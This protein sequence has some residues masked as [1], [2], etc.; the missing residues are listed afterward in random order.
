MI[1]LSLH[2]KLFA[3][4]AASTGY[5][6]SFHASFPAESGIGTGRQV[7]GGTNTKLG[8]PAHP[9]T[10]ESAMF[11]YTGPPI[12]L[13]CTSLVILT[14]LLSSCA[15][16]EPPFEC[17]DPLGC[18]DLPPEAPI[19]IGVLQ[20]LS[21]KIASLG[22]EQVR[23]IELAVEKR[24]GKALGRS[25]LLQIENTGC[26]GEGGAN[27]ALKLIADPMIPAIIGTTCSGAARTA[28]R[29]MSEAG[30]TM[31]SG[32]N[33]APYLTSITGKAAPDFQPGYFRTAYNEEA[34]GK[35][36][37]IFAYEKLEIRKAAAINDG[38]IY[39]SG[40]TAGFR[41][42]F[43]ELGGT[44]SLYTSV[45]KGE[46]EMGPV[47]SAVVDSGAELLFFP[48]FQPEGNHILLQARKTP[49]L[50][51]TVLMSDG[52]LVDNTFIEAVK[53]KGRGMYFVGP[54]YPETPEGIALADDYREKY[55]ES[56]V[57]GYYR[58]AFDA[59]NL[60]LSAIE[61]IAVK[62][63]SGML[64]IGRKALRDALYAT[65][66]VAGVTGELNCDR[67][68]D[69][70]S[71]VFDVLLL[72]DPAKGVEGLRANAVFTYAPGE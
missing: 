66:E 54:N 64:H 51:K 21:G 46:K 12:K 40:L 14:V 8:T 20:A 55:R 58:T 5:A 27:A 13:L 11:T 59:A 32:N 69:C 45:N 4:P 56:P 28:S 1:E 39:T 47:L 24:G 61:K 37:A 41:N 67:F 44:M 57:V 3:I 15:K 63:A 25:I 72:E 6:A 60:L 16:Q 71:P 62:D 34:A 38:D 2:F 42:S 26:S 10:K 52:A 36:A 23:G 22:R 53:A 33:S 65:R 31:I 49:G 70:A 29:A 43:V 30:L 18:V 50:E 19:R 9:L 48:L 17:T 7:A 35:T 68:G